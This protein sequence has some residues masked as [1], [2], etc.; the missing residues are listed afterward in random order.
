MALPAMGRSEVVLRVAA[1][2]NDIQS[3]QVQS[4]Y[5]LQILAKIKLLVGIQ[6]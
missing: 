6:N 2:A 1:R 3:D 4:A 5:A